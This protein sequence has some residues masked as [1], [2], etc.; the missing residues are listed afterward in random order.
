MR[1]QSIIR[2]KRHGIA[3]LALLG[4]TSGCS[5]SGTSGA[6][7]VD[8][9][10]AGAACTWGG[11][12]GKRGFNGDG[13]PLAE[14]W[15]GFVSDLT[16]DPEGRA[17]IMDWNNHRVRRVESDQTLATIIG[18]DYE[19]DG[20]PGETDRLP[21]GDPEGALCTTVAL[22]H[23][24]DIGFMSDGTIVLAA[25]HNNKIR[26]MDPKTQI[27]TVMAGNGYGYNGDDGAAYLAEFNQPKSIA[28]DDEDRV[29][30]NDQRN[31]RIRRI[32]NGKPRQIT[33]IAGTGE[34]GFSGDGGAALAAQFYFDQGTTPL[35]SGA[36]AIR[37]NDLFV[38]DSLNHRIR[39]IDL[40][41][42]IIETIAGNGTRGYSG[43]GGPALKASL[44]EPLDIELGPDGRLYVADSFNN[45]IRAIDLKAGTIQR[46]AG[47]AEQCPAPI[48]CFEDLEGGAALDLQLSVPYGIEFDEHGALYISDTNN[49]RIVRVAP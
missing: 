16:F 33:N 26:V 19:G 23:P 18:A 45:A 32:D 9:D 28:I 2:S 24:T 17:W 44:N 13:L 11:V 37:S 31:Q 20:P 27:V 34:K 41:T 29:Y 4:S 6:A 21:V 42:G 36:L 5:D 48:N 25:W 7:E 46:V 22:N 47:N 49:S 8:C 38:A 30:L 15:L 10:A 14:S 43:D 35:P 12:K 1:N 40:D 3:L 39:H